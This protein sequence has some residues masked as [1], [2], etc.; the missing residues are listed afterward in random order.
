M[1]TNVVV[2]VDEH[3]GGRDAIALGKELLDQNGELTLAYV[4]HG[5]PHAWR[6][7]SAAYDTAERERSLELLA[8]A[9]DEGAVEAQLR[10]AGASSVGRGLHVLAETAGADLLVVG[11]SRRGL[12]GR[13]MLGDDTR[14]ALNGAPCAVAI[15][16]TG[17]SRYP[18]LM[19]E[20]GVGYNT[21][22]ESE[23]ALAV[24]RS[25]AAGRGAKLSAFEAVTLPASFF[26]GALGP[27]NEAIEDFVNEASKRVAGLEGVEPHAAYG[28]P[29]EELAL[30][31]ASVDLL[32]VGSRSYGPIGRLVHGSTSQQLARTAPLSAARSDPGRSGGRD[33]GRLAR[34]AGR[35]DRSQSLSELVV[36]SCRS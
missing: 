14:A 35:C 9:R 5:E 36:R 8:R 6:G 22:P 19:R 17:Y 16:P 23:H 20:I 31:G 30:Y 13:V 34:R 2:G 4:Y 26:A 33:V 28:H 15:A 21:S 25:L 24:A 18:V 27:L 3:E 11:S 10:C 29:A 12:L 7:S 32:V 1:F